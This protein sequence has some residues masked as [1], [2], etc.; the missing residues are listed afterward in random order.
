MHALKKH[1]LEDR[2]HV[3]RNGADAL[4]FVFWTGAYANRRAANPLVILLDKNLPIVDGLVVLRM[5]RADPR[6]RLIPVV[7]LTSSAEERDIIESYRL[8]V[9]SY[10]IKPVDFE[11]FGE[12]V[13]ALGCYWMVLNRPPIDVRDLSQSNSAEVL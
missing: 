6:T 11:K 2:L 5:I 8:G 10:I 13:R 7:M 4:E 9:N 1:H 3:A 12:A